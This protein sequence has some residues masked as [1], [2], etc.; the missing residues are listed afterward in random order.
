MMPQETIE[1]S[2]RSRHHDL[3]DGAGGENQFGKISGS[4]SSG[5]STALELQC[6]DE[7]PGVGNKALRIRS[8]GNALLGERPFV[9]P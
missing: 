3:D 8:M 2:S 6:Q 7:H 1:K 9:Q 4:S 5:R